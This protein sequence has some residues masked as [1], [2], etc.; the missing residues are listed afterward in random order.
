MPVAPPTSG[1]LLQNPLV[2]E[3][4]AK[5]WSDSQLA[6]RAQRHEEGGWIFMDTTTGTISVQRQSPG[7]QAQLDLSSPPLVPGSVVVGKFHT[8]PNP[9]SEGW[10][11]GPSAQDQIVDALHGVP[12]LIRADDGMHT[13]GPDSRRGG[14][15]GG[16]GFPP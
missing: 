3:G 11:P 4:I 6:D 9:T 7:Q 12:D 1:E 5:P 8:H 16:P 13:S 2:Q 10:D 14:L 15:A